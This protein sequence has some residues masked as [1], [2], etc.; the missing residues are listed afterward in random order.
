MA[1][2]ETKN[3]GNVLEDVSPEADHMPEYQFD[4]D[5]KRTSNPI[6]RFFQY[7]ASWMIPGLGMFAEAC[8][9]WQWHSLSALP[10]CM[11]AI[12]LTHQ[13]RLPPSF[14]RLAA[15]TSRMLPFVY[16]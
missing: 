3:D 13:A 4:A 14:L 15:R 6:A 10:T 9:L 2:Q 16:F 1:R 5:E 8:V 12:T 11:S 7:L